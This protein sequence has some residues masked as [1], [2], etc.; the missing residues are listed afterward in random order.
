MRIHLLL[1]SCKKNVVVVIAMS[2]FDG[3]SKSNVCLTGSCPCWKKRYMVPTR[4]F[5]NL[6][7][8]EPYRRH[9]TRQSK[10]C[11]SRKGF[12]WKFSQLTNINSS[13]AFSL[14]VFNLHVLRSCASSLCTPF[15]FMSFLVTAYHLSF[16]LPIFRC[17]P[18]SMFS[19]L[20]L[21]LH[22]A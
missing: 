19:L 10:V 4:R 3:A 18:A 1:H 2:A 11:D 15:S 9:H 14:F 22:M 13:S 17:P 8:P 6:T 20:H 5:G 12:S 7:L 21:S 16:G